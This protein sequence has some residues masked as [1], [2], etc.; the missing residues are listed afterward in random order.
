MF[1]VLTH[2]REGA[3]RVHAIHLSQ[4]G[5]ARSAQE[6]AATYPTVKVVP[7]LLED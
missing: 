2:D 5:A 7:T 6:A 1:V 4:D 3:C